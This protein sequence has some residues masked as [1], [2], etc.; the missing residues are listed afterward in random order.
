MFN[1]KEPKETRFATKYSDSSYV[2]EGY[3]KI[4]IDKKTGV[5]YLFH[6]LGSAGG[7][8]VLLDENGKPVID[9]SGL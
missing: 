4:I 3:T 8:T 5:N 6:G 7:L 9:K 1:K 2:I